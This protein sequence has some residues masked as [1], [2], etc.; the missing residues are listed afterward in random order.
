MKQKTIAI[1]F[2]AITIFAL[3][4][5]VFVKTKAQTA[6]VIN[7]KDAPYSAKGDGVTDDT[8]AIQAAVNAAYS[9]GGGSTGS[10]AEVYFPNGTY[11]VTSVSIHENIIYQGQSKENTIIQRPGAPIVGG[12]PVSITRDNPAKLTTSL[13]HGISNGSF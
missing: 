2:L 10:G 7:V 4:F 13:P 5:L 9:Q 3:S 1:I 8:A 6:I 12:E 11:I